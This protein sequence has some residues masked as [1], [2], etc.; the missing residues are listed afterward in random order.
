M[1]YKRLS[2]LLAGLLAAVVVVMVIH[3][4]RVRPAMSVDAVCDIHRL[5]ETLQLTP[6]QTIEIQRLH[7][8][9]ARTLAS[10]CGQHCQAQAALMDALFAST[11]GLDRSQALI[12]EMSRAQAA[13]EMATLVNIYRVRDVLT[14]RQREIYERQVKSMNCMMPSGGGGSVCGCRK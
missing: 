13:S 11:N 1:N 14:P 2:F 5:K 3:L 12:D 6:S 10:C 7:E 4:Y 9:L 8:E